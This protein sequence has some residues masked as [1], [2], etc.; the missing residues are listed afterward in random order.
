MPKK[1]KKEKILAEIH[2]KNDF[3]NQQLTSVKS[4]NQTTFSKSPTQT[5]NNYKYSE[6]VIIKPQI[7]TQI[8]DYSII[9]H[10]LIKITIFT[11]IAFSLQG[12]IYFLLR[13][14]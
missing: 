2:R 13:T 9:K 11:F 8:A 6:M 4:Q 5:K 3:L 10:D 1:T 14:R 7:S 12:M